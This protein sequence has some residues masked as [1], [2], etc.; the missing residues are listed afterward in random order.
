[1]LN[2]LVWYDTNS[3]HKYDADNR[4]EYL[5]DVEAILVLYLALEKIGAKH[6]EVFSLD[7]TRLD[8]NKGRGGLHGH[9]V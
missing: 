1:M 5:A 9:N 8:P 4:Y 2:R 6:V 7:G 3:G